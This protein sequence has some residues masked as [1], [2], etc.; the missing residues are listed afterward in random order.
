[1]P[2]PKYPAL[3]AMTG[4]FTSFAEATAVRQIDSHTYSA[5]LQDDWSVGNVPH[6]GIVTSVFL[7]VAS[8]HF[9]T[10]LRAS[11]QPHTIALHLDFL[12][13][14]QAGPAKLVVKDLKLGRQTSVIHITLIQDDREE[15][16]GTLTHSNIRTESGLSLDTG[17]SLHPPRVPVDTSKLRGGTDPNWALLESVAQPKFRKA[18]TKVTTWLP[19]QGQQ[20]YS[21]ADEWITFSTGER[22]TNESLGFVCDVW[23]LPIRP[24]NK[25]HWL[26]TLVLNLD[27]KK[28]LPAGGVE[29][30]FVRVQTKRV[31]NGRFDL[32]VVI[33]DEE[34]DIVALS[35]HAGLILGAERNLASRAEREKL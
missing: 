25:P 35:H 31:V 22:F 10:T 12:R 26:P 16:S 20:H 13:R 21:L 7:Q 8:K 1:M 28:A 18:Y 30:L 19:R 27:I 3:P 6:G 4:Q 5:S 9:A 32:E 14:T 2:D 17:Y 34:G 23:P 24:Q 11:G 29:F 15:V 33:M